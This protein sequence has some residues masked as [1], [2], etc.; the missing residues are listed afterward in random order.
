MLT[1][2]STTMLGMLLPEEGRW[3]KRWRRYSNGDRTRA[4]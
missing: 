3:R 1:G 4:G 2:D